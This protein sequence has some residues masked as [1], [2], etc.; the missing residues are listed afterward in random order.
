MEAVPGWSGRSESRGAGQRG[1]FDGVSNPHLRLMLRHIWLTAGETSLSSG[2]LMHQP[3]GEDGHNRDHTGSPLV[4]PP[5]AVSPPP[6]APHLLTDVSPCRCLP[7]C[8]SPPSFAWTT[9][10]F[11]QHQCNCPISPYLLTHTPFK[12]VASYWVFF[13]Q[14]PEKSKQRI[15]FV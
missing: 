15:P 5:P 4:S 1:R 13:F 7:R 6:P 2:R 3:P 12:S 9:E 14:I 10:P 8:L 11:P